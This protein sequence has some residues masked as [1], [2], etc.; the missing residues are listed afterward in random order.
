MR[1]I[2]HITFISVTYFHLLLL[3]SV[4]QE[5]SISSR[6]IL[7]CPKLWNVSVCSAKILIL[8]ILASM[9]ITTIISHTVGGES[10]L[11]DSSP[12]T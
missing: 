11:T 5:V 3:K 12:K 7:K 4:K 9:L 10:A 8:G 6:H 2:C 1:N